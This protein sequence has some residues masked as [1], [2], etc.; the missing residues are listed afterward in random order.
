MSDCSTCIVRN[1]AICASLDTDELLLL[2]KLGRKRTIS[3]GETLLWEGDPAPVVAN[4][5]DGVLKLSVNLQDGREQIVSV[6]YASDF[7]GRPFGKESPY[8]VTAMTDAEVCV[9]SRS[10]FDSFA[11]DHPD[12][13]NKLLQR[14]LDEL[15]R[16]REWMTL[17]G[18]KSAT[19]R[20]A[21]L[22]IELSDRL[23]TDGCSPVT[24]YL[25]RFA[26]PMDRQQISDILGLT[27]ETVSRQFTRI[28]KEGII[29]LPDRR[30][31]I[32]KDRNRLKALAEVE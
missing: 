26:L 3:R 2:G 25:D 16:A 29:E 12:L 13:Q 11:K 19:E 15:D 10:S 21:T 4:I 17:L 1:R 9:F 28:R 7:I 30:T 24:P 20:I 22:L 27:I 32:I 18:K 5:I 6:M 8:R 31:V 23:S 14:T